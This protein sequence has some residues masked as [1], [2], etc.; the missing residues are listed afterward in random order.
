[1]TKLTEKIY[2]ASLI[3][4]AFSLNTAD[5]NAQTCTAAPD[6]ATLGFTK[7]SSDCDGHSVLKCPFDQSKL[8]CD[9]GTTAATPNPT[10]STYKVG[11]TY[12]N[13]GVP[14]GKVIEIKDNGAHGLVSTIGSYS[15]TYA[16]AGSGCASLSA[17]GL[18][19]FLPTVKQI[20]AIGN[21]SRFDGYVWGSSGECV[22][23]YGSTKNVT[24]NYQGQTE[25]SYSSFN[26]YCNA[27]DNDKH[28][29]IDTSLHVQS[30]YCVASF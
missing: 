23:N 2:G 8:Y 4:L 6:C 29:N 27:D 1:M 7:S 15:G 14:V 18:A 13:N 17:D 20:Q 28:Q 9:A 30:Y 5:V 21:V 16:S 19:W 3:A 10:T 24:C 11:D 22:N 25:C 12:Y 26:H